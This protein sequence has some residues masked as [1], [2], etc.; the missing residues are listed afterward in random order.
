[1]FTSSDDTHIS[2]VMFTRQIIL[3]HN[4]LCLN[5]TRKDEDFQKMRGRIIVGGEEFG[6]RVNERYKNQWES[7]K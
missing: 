6:M 7:L 2:Y 3:L 5:Y 1:M 4:K